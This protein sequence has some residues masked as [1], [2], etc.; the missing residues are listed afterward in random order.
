MFEIHDSDLLYHAV[1][2]LFESVMV[3]VKYTACFLQIDELRVCFLP[4]K[5]RD[6]VKVVIQ[7]TCFDPFFAFLTQTIEN[8]FSLFACCLIHA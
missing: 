2:D 3:F 4:V 1:F 5:G 7:H 8:F 6:K